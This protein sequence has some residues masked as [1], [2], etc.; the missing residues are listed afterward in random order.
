MP[1]QYH[2]SA[3]FCLVSAITTPASAMI[4]GAGQS[5][6]RDGRS[7]CFWRIR[8]TREETA[9][10]PYRTTISTAVK[11]TTVISEDWKQR[12]DASTPT[13]SVATHGAPRRGSTLAIHELTGSGQA[14]S[15]PLAHTILANCNVMATEALKIAITA[16]VT[17]ARPTSAREPRTSSAKLIPLSYPSTENKAVARAVSMR[18]TP[19]ADTPLVPLATTGWLR[20]DRGCCR[21]VKPA[22][23]SAPTTSSSSARQ[24]PVNQ[25][26]NLIFSRH[27][28]VTRIIPNPEASLVE[29][30][31][32]SACT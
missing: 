10:S 31:E 3:L 6:I 26:L 13:I 2:R 9:I 12:M 5:G 27:T 30:P 11:V 18:L 16:A 19:I 23:A 8:L 14:L 1:A 20:I 28:R 24:T 29:M 4:G 22:T 7:R 25:A 15:R 17:T 32:L 21:C